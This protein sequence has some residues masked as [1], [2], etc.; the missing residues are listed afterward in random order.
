MLS[1]LQCCCYGNMSDKMISGA[2]HSPI[3]YF[4][5]FLISDLETT[6]LLVFVIIVISMV[7]VIV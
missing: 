3:T 6:L 7:R 5:S 1:T 4:Y 2:R